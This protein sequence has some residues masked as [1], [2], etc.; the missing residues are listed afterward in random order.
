MRTVIALVVISLGVS[1]AALAQELS[2][3][4]P[5]AGCD[6]KDIRDVKNRICEARAAINEYDRLDKYLE[7]Q[8]Q[9][10]G[11]PIFLNDP[12]RDRINKGCAQ[13]AVDLAIDRGAKQ[14]VAQT[15]ANCNIVN[16]L[17]DSACLQEGVLRHEGVH[18]DAC[19]KRED[20]KWAQVWKDYWSFN[21]LA[22]AIINTRF[23]M[24]AREFIKEEKTA[25]ETELRHYL[26]VFTSMKLVCKYPG[27]FVVKYPDGS[28]YDTSAH[29]CPSRPRPAKGAPDSKCELQ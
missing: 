26:T 23:T 24:S 25:S 28:T 15:E 10:G 9:R 3:L 29:P 8:E 22:G 17:A 20:G 5:Y 1:T 4:L 19:Y 6:C 18:R 7:G 16:V 14:A 13:E 12:L 11:Q 27:D 2:P 21:N